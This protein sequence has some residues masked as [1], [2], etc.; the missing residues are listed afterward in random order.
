MAGVT[1]NKYLYNKTLSQV[2]VQPHDSPFW[3]GLMKVKDE[4]IKRGSFVAN[5]GEGARFWEDTWL[6]NRPCWCQVDVGICS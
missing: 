4:F 1:K 5:S 2:T 3:R 6:G